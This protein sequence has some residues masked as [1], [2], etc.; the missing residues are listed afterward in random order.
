[1]DIIPKGREWYIAGVVLE[2][3]IEDD[4]RNVIHVNS[5]LVHATSPEDA[6]NKA[7][8]LGN[9]TERVYVNTDNKEVTV[10]FRGLSNLLEIYDELEHGG[11]LFYREHIGVPESEIAKMVRE[12]S[13]LTVFALDEDGPDVPNYM[14][15]Q[16]MRMLESHARKQD[17]LPDTLPRYPEPP[18]T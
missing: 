7:I 4:S 1:M 2:H 17:N 5:L 3:L 18:G 9:E 12:K 11:E 16:V 10:R 15:Q 6:Y 8:Q 14:P 13:K